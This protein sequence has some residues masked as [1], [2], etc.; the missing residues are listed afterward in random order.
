MIDE[1]PFTEPTP[2]SE[3]LFG[4]ETLDMFGQVRIISS[5]P[6]PTQPTD[7]DEQTVVLVS[8]IVGPNFSSTQ[9][10]DKHESSPSDSSSD[11]E[12]SA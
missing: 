8:E 10:S 2:L 7:G 4:S 11:D 1:I 12:Q 9:S 6:E 3:Q 5:V